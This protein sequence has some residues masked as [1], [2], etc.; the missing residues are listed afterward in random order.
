VSSANRL[1]VFELI[2]TPSS[3][4]QTRN[5]FILSAPTTT[6]RHDG[7]WFCARGLRQG[8]SVCCWHHR[9][10]HLHRYCILLTFVDIV[11]GPKSFLSNRFSQHLENAIHLGTSFYLYL[12]IPLTSLLFLIIVLILNL[13]PKKSV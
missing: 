4:R 7:P 13:L 2:A 3:L 12:N 8:I 1:S 11:R 9:S 10:S 5:L 6:D